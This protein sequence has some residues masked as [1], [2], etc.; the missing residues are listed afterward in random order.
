MIESLQ[1]KEDW[2]CFQKDELFEFRPGVNLLV[3]D[4]GSGKSSIL[5][6]FQW[7]ISNLESHKK[8]LE[9]LANIKCQS[10][11]L[12][13]FDFEKQNPRTKSRIDHIADVALRWTSHGAAV[14]A[15][16]DVLKEP[17]EKAKV[18]IMDEPD[19]ALSVRSIH[20]II[21]TLQ[22]TK[23]QVIAAVHN[24]FL[25]Q[26]FPEVLSMEHRR[27]MPSEEFL[28]SQKHDPSEMFLARNNSGARSF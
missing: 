12:R 8:T 20:K 5:T 13:F 15:I 19:M 2:R 11:E 27:W 7:A 25:I 10:V 28:E 9:Q 24:P 16:I 17:S 18:F 6:F 1:L 14:L 23:H 3:G 4:Q 26:A 22:Q 21:I